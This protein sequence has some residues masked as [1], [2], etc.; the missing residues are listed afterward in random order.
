[1]TSDTVNLPLTYTI[2]TVVGAISEI[3]LLMFE[4]FRKR[5]DELGL[6]FVLG[7]LVTVFVALGNVAEWWWVAVIGVATTVIGAFIY[8][9]AQH[10]LRHTP[11]HL[12]HEPQPA[13]AG[14]QHSAEE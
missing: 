3:A 7:G 2:I 10:D 11:L 1:M 9:S 8:Y 14:F 12:H 4:A 5:R 6:L 13:G